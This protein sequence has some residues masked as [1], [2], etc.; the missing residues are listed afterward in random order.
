M[1]YRVCG[2]AKV[3]I[4]VRDNQRM[5]GGNAILERGHDTEVSSENNERGMRLCFRGLAFPVLTCPS[6]IN[7]SW[8]SHV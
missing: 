1:Y 7:W 3:R 2:D 6:Y 8:V 5:E 4:K